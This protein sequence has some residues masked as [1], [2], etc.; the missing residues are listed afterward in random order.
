MKKTI[1]GIF[2]LFVVVSL[3]KVTAGQDAI[4]APPDYLFSPQFQTGST[5]AETGQSPYFTHPEFTNIMT[6]TVTT[7]AQNTGDGYIFVT[8]SEMFYDGPSALMILEN[9]GEPVYIQTIPDSPFIGDFKKQIVNGTEYLT[10]YAVS[11]PYGNP[12]RSFYVLDENYQLADSWSYTPGYNTDIHEFL[13]LENGHAIFIAYVLIPYDLSPWG[14]PVDGILVDVVLQEQDANKNVVFEW[15]ASE[16]LP[17]GDTQME[18]NTTEPLDFLHTNA[19]EVD[20][21]GNWLLSHRH[22]SEITKINR[23]T[24]EIIWRMGG[25]SNEFTFTN[26]IGFSFQHDIRRLENGN[27]TLFDN[28]NFHSPPHSRAIEYAIDEVAKTVT[29][30]WSYPED[31]SEVSLAMGNFQRLPNGNSF[32]GWGTQPKVSEVEPDGTLALEIEMG[33][34]MYRA[35]RYPWNGTPIESPRTAVQYSVDPT[36]VTLYTSWNGATDI[37]SYDVY[38]G[39]TLATLSKITNVPRSGFETEIP[40][41]GLPAD[42]CF[43]RTQ[44]IHDEGNLTPFSNTVFRVD[45]PVC[46][47]QLNHSFNPVMV[48]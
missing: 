47:D 26:D 15:F 17:I 13:L 16:H 1:T 42:T 20:D 6:T 46:W 25:K 24:G 18:I 35:F 48:K 33:S 22:F 31:E 2:L 40:L 41:S 29:R 10:F 9:T 30:V 37:V 36:T 4:V 28:G 45:L 8:P 21:D 38:A 14:G 43:F 3:S 7:P 12:Y 44:P 19:I 39:P 34:I 23:Q 32:I 27:I 5:T 11:L